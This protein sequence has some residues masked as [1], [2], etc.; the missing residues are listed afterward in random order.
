MSRDMRS[1]RD[2]T[3]PVNARIVFDLDGTLIDSAPDIQKIANAGLA[4][5]GFTNF[6]GKRTPSLAKA[7]RTS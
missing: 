2:E 6:L 1:D 3:L 4:E 7:F 5:I